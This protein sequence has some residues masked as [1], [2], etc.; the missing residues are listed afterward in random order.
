MDIILIKTNLI[1]NIY[2]KAHISINIGNLFLINF[3]TPSIIINSK[4]EINKTHVHLIFQNPFK[5]HF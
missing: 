5:Y 4:H 2:F 3:V 1:T